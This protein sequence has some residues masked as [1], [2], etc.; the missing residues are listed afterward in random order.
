M[1][2]SWSS[3]RNS[4][5]KWRVVCRFWWSSCDKSNSASASCLALCASGEGAVSKMREGACGVGTGVCA[6]H[7]R[8]MRKS[9]GG[10][11]WSSGPIIGCGIMVSIR[12]GKYLLSIR[13]SLA[14][15]RVSRILLRSLPSCWEL[16]MAGATRRGSLIVRGIRAVAVEGVF[17]NG[18]CCD[19]E[20]GRRL[21]RRR[22]VEAGE[23]SLSEG[24]I[25]VP[26]AAFESRGGRLRG[27]KGCAS[28]RRCP[29]L[30]RDVTPPELG[31]RPE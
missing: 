1:S 25:G 2:S 21:R 17:A 6:T 9:G 5:P 24:S 11:K 10:W 16:V 14:L 19:G 28:S 31:I 22:R 3:G 8:R 30:A 15:A 23:L 12:A 13:A 29:E 18:V 4:D 20:C 26:R 27:S 7:R